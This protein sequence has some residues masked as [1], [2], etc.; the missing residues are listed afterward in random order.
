[1]FTAGAVLGLILLI[2]LHIIV[3]AIDCPLGY[4]NGT[5]GRAHDAV[6]AGIFQIIENS[7]KFFGLQHNRHFPFPEQIN[8]AQKILISLTEF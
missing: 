6:A 5:I 4:G 3:K 1:M 8:S 2:L 7:F